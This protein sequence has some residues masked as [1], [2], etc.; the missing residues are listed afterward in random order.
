MGRRL[1]PAYIVLTKKGKTE[2]KTKKEIAEKYG[3]KYPY[4]VN[5]LLITGF[6]VY[7]EEYGYIYVHNFFCKDCDKYMIEDCDCNWRKDR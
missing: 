4:Q 2:H 7:S 3:L 5:W 1:R 6:S